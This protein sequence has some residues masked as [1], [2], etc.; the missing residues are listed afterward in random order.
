MAD[1]LHALFIQSRLWTGDVS[2]CPIIW[3]RAVQQAKKDL[4]CV[5]DVGGESTRNDELEL[6]KRVPRDGLSCRIQ[7]ESSHDA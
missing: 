3:F 5:K 2:P 6:A 7:P 4:V 1:V